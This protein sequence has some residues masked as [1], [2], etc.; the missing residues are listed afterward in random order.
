MRGDKR[1]YLE[2]QVHDSACL[3]FLAMVWMRRK[4]IPQAWELRRWLPVYG[5]HEAV[6]RFSGTALQMLAVAGS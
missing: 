4:K 1:T 3:E 2:R 6:S 5:R